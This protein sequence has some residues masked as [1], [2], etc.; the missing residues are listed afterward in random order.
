MKQRARP[1]QAHYADLREVV[2]HAA[3]HYPEQ[4]F[5]FC[6]DSAMPHVTGSEL[7]SLCARFC[8]WAERSGL[9]GRHIALLGV[10]S[11]AWLS[12]FFAVISGGGVIVPLHL[13]S[14]A[15]ELASCLRRSDS[16]VLLYDAAC[17]QDVA[18]LRDVLP[19]LELIE[20]H[21]FLDA[22]R[23]EPEMR[24]P[25][26]E[27]D[28]AAALYFTS[29]T[30][31]LSRCVL[32]T[33]R[34]MGS[35][36]SA[37]MSQLPLSPADTGLS[38]LPLSHTF[39]I[40]TNIVG[41]LHC[42]G[43]MYINESLLTVKSNLKKYEPTILVVVPLV[44]QMLHKEIVRTA[45]RQGRLELLQKGLRINGA[46]Q[47]LGLDFSRRLF[48]E[49]YDV[50]GG[51]LRYFLCGGAALDPELI[52]F[53]QRLGITVL[54]GYGITECCPIVAANVPGA[55][56]PGSVGRTFPC[57]ETAILDGEICVRGDSVSPGYY[58][59]AEANAE[60]Y[61]GGWF[62]TG[63][64]GRID[65]K[66]YLY[67]LGR[68][69]NLIVLSNGENVS[70][71]LLEEKLYRVEGITDAVVYEKNGKITAEV[72]PDTDILPDRDAVW[73]EIDRV[74]RTLKPHEQIGALTLR[75]EPFEK[76]ATQKIKRN[77]PKE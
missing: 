32:L 1:P 47:R 7:K 35:H 10:N 12:A 9:A 20:L 26:L 72:Y 70:P 50:L 44:L 64:L 22:L 62:H 41:V 46:A 56:R 4:P 42:G 55:N 60:A 16:A 71:E 65:K 6:A 49:V 69:K 30:T 31:A 34:N 29:G 11:A 5:F 54:Q 28:A 74:N 59:D 18:P 67:F 51:K 21:A 13:G 58:N 68:R 2:L 37:A 63:D 77:R 48:P 66:G 25:A 27:P 8:P 36:C 45:K 23:A 17:E 61:R 52:T 38:V 53:F 40:M 24:F 39:E 43:E 19:E 33:H 15:E 3:A 57:C 76:T 73:R 75:S 14:K